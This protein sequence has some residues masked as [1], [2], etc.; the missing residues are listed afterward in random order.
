MCI[1]QSLFSDSA[2]RGVAITYRIIFLITNADMANKTCLRAGDEQILEAIFDPEASGVVSDLD[3]Q[4]QV[5]EKEQGDV[6]DVSRAKELE[7]EAVK[8]AESGRLDEALQLLNR[9][10]EVAPG[11]ASPYN[12]RAQ[13]YQLQK[14]VELAMVDLERAIELSGGRG[15]AGEQAFVQRGIIWRLKGEDDKAT[16]DF[17]KAAKLGSKFAQMQ[18]VKLN[19]YAALCNQMLTQMIEKERRGEATER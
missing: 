15:K 16:E 13:V 5:G 9:A 6:G 1:T 19:P 3:A 14:Q 11:Y 2:V 17:K 18:V 10:V 4:E 7:L 12:N 8:A